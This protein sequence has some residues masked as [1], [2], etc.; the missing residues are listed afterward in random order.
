MKIE[1]KIKE[2]RE[3]IEEANYQY[4]TLDKPVISDQQYDAL[5]KELI[6]LEEAN[7]QFKDDHSPTQKIGG[8][9][10]DGFEKV[11]HVTPM[12]SLNNC[13][14]I[15]EL[16]QF[17]NRIDKEFNNISY[18]TELKIDGLAISLFYENGLFI[19]AVTRGDGLVGEDVTE[20]V[21]TIRSLP[22]KLNEPLT[23][24]VR[25]EVFI[26]R[27]VFDALN[28]D[29][30]LKGEVLFA[31]PRNMA[32]GTLRQLNPKIVRERKLDLFVYFLVT[33]VEGIN[34]Q[35]KALDKLK[36]LGFKVNNYYK[37]VNNLTEL[38]NVISEYDKIRKQLDYETDGVV[39]KVND[40]NI[41]EELGFTA[42]YPRWAIAYKFASEQAETKVNDIVFQVGRTGAI[43][44]V[45]NLEPVMLSGSLVSRATLHNYDYISE[46]DV[47]VGDYVI[48]HK[49]GEIIPEVIEVVM[50][51]RTNQVKTEMI[52]NCPICET[53][54]EKEE[55]KVDYFCPNP[56][57]PAKTVNSIIHFVSRGAMNI[58]T[59]GEKNIKQLYDL[60]Y[61]P[62]IQ[63]IYSLTDHY[64]ELI[65]IKGF[66]KR[67][68]SKL[69]EAV[70]ESK[71]MSLSNLLFGLGIKHVGSKMAQTLA[72]HFSNIDNLLNTNYDELINLEAVGPEI[73]NS[74]I[75]YIN[76]PNNV[77]LINTLKESGVNMEEEKIKVDNTHQFNGKTFVL[78]GS[79]QTFTRREAATLIESLGGK[80][81]SSVS[82]NTDYVLVGDSPGSKYEKAVSLNIT[83]LT[84]EEFKEYTRG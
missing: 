73:A 41:Q 39:V 55:P 29:R 15:E 80:I 44:P 67:K 24:E 11:V 82:K 42:R 23:I 52:T 48:V 81:T 69:L 4:H 8:K 26:K 10:L 56:S 70:E 54:L 18:T 53:K 58:D 37:V 83:I 40:F 19:R 46:K 61:L 50:E 79:L 57:C 3:K 21:K 45:A 64:D 7:P 43:T 2:L 51:K 20:N 31:N 34:H 66:G 59:L 60:G 76:E 65:K 16:T 74:V 36:K 17:Y 78:T 32:S 35:N 9:I 14:N 22:L 1:L 6:E 63:S 33:P 49:A 84:E 68:V 77:E 71:K 28:K 75:N 38:N 62:N 25:G 27:S 12:M 72:N 13:F 30:M 5:M 47:R